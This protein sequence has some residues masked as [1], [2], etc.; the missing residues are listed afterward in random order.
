M[1]SAKKIFCTSSCNELHNVARRFS[2]VVYNIVKFR[3]MN[4]LL[5]IIA[6][7]VYGIHICMP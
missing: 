3:K 6:R 4:V 5:A 2:F 7:S 1:I